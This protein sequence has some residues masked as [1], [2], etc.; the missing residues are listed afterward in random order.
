MNDSSPTSSDASRPAAAAGEGTPRPRQ[1]RWWIV[2][3]VLGVAAIGAAIWY[4]SGKSVSAVPGA[5]RAAGSEKGGGG[6]KGGDPASRVTPVVAAPVTQG[7]LDIYLYALGTVTPLNAVTV[8]SRV[9]GQLMKV[10]FE[11][12]Q[13]VKKGDLLALIDPRPF[14][15]Q[16]T[17]ASG[18]QARNKALLENARVDVQRYRTLL[19]QDSISKQQVDTQ[20]SL[21]RQYEAAVQAD[22]GNIDNAKLQLTYTR[23]VAPISGR[24][25]L[26]QVDPGNIVRA[27]DANGIVVIT[28][29]SPIGV[30]FPIP[31]DQLPRV[32]K[33]LQAGDRIPVE[34]YDR[35]QKEKLGSGRLLTADNQIDP[36][37]G[38]IKLKSEFPNTDGTLFANQFVNVR[39]PVETRPN[40]TLAPTAAIQRG[41]SGTFVYVVKDD[42]TVTVTPV[43]IGSTQGEITSIDSGLNP[44]ALVVVDGADRLREGARVEVVTRDATAPSSP[45][46][47]RRGPRGGKGGERG[48]KD[49]KVKGGA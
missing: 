11:E 20:E 2:I 19:A 45:D 26:R 44:G 4:A 7:T 6:G 14:E 16:L 38:T 39:M 17:L 43:S 24:V 1:A 15:V 23:V 13:M 48:A 33:R 28:Q 10:A 25:G 35:A 37:T 22:Q 40:A 12:G 42:K 3:V 41:V 31:E 18:Q 32:M 34:A 9:D 36:A 30:V 47:A 5:P 21:V 27:A 29:L 46:A 49:S 8:R